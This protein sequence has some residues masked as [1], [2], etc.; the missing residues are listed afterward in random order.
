MSKSVA[1]ITWRSKNR[2]KSAK[3]AKKKTKGD[4]QRSAIGR[5]SKAS[6]MR[7]N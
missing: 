7:T 2:M 3:G 5:L 4:R 1:S 6:V